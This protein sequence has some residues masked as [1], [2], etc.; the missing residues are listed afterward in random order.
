MNSKRATPR[1]IIIKM[2]EVKDKWIILKV[3]WEKQS[4]TRKFA[5]DTDNGL[6]SKIHKQHIQ[7][8]E[9]EKPNQ[10]LAEVN[11]TFLQRKH[12]DGQKHMKRYPTLLIIREMQI[13][14]TMRYHLTSVR[15]IIIR[16]SKHNKC[17]RGHGKEELSYSAGR[18]K[19][20]Y[21]HYAEQ[22]GCFFKN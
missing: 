6:I 7:L 20:W 10:K 19:N 1:H 15:T 9:T 13:K 5:Q 22:Y 2:A 14:T 4:L 17:W 12:A 21:G 16:M 18:N 11:Q 3:I 8:K